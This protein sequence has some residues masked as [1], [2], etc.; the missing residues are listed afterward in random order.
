MAVAAPVAPP[1]PGAIPTAPD[2]AELQ[3]ALTERDKQLETIGQAKDA[4]LDPIR[5][6]AKAT[7][8]ATEKILAKP[9]DKVP[10]PQNMAKHLDPKQLN[11]TAQIFM[12]LGALGGLFM[13]QPLTAALG[14]MTAAMKGVQAGDAEQF[15]RA[16]EEFQTNFDK[17]MKINDAASKERTRILNDNK[18]S[19]TEKMN[20]LDIEAAKYG[21]QTARV[22]NSFKGKM[23]LYNAKEKAATDARKAFDSWQTKQAQ[24]QHWRNQDANART[25]AAGAGGGAGGAAGGLSDAAKQMFA[26]MQ[27]R[28]I[29]APDISGRKEVA[30]QK[31]QIANLMAEKYAAD[32]TVPTE[33]QVNRDMHAAL[34]KA[35]VQT[36]SRVT[37]IELG[38]RKIEKDIKTL[39][40]Y[41]AAGSPDHAKI[42]GK[43]ENK[44]RSAVSDPTLAPYALAVKQV[45]TEYERLMVGGMLSVAQ[46]H[47]GAREDAKRILS[48]DMTIAEVNSILPVMLA[49][50]RNQKEAAAETVADLKKQIGSVGSKTEGSAPSAALTH[51]KAHPELKEQFK[52]KYGYLPE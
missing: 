28:G 48:E 43:L 12:T 1:A 27:M 9:I 6:S 22:T 52:A 25:R 13:R 16:T 38:S 3:T 8:D 30:Q 5:D 33:I 39:E 31:I 35:L 23:E 17:A 34:T 36:T 10:L 7:I 18:L 51:L 4:T 29:K 26:D 21:D 19:L 24:I 44:I 15:D 32:G 50:I 14:N 41:M 37:G 47:E 49:E 45:A 11:D 20:L 46:L 2:P 42:I 40:R